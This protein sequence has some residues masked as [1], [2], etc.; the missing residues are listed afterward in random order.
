MPLLFR[1][2]HTINAGLS[3]SILLLL[4]WPWPN[5]TYTLNDR[6]LTYTEFWSSGLAPVV[7]LFFLFLFLL[8]FATVKRKVIAQY[9]V[10]VYWSL[11]IGLFAY[12]SVS[13]LIVGS[14]LLLA[15]GWYVF[16]NAKLKLY[17]KLNRVQQA[18]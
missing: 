16:T 15:W 4:F 6:E 9:G 10:F 12:G 11:F 17:F 3:T 8:C 13:G 14:M 5:A 18:D 7:F 2:L 1:F